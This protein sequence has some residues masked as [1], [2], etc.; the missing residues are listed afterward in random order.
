MIIP[1]IAPVIDR[2][3]R[4]MHPWMLLLLVIIPLVFW[5]YYKIKSG[6]SLK[7]SSL[8]NLRGIKRSRKAI[9][10]SRVPALFFLSLALFIFALARPQSGTTKEKMHTDG[11][12][13]AIS[14][15]I[16]SSMK[17]VD[18]KPENRLGAAKKVAKDF[19]GERENDRIS[20]VI[21]AAH[22]FTQC[23]LTMDYGMI[24]NFLDKVEIGQ[25]EDGTAIGLGLA[26]AANRLANSKSKSKVIVLLTDGVNNRG[27]ID[28]ITAS[29][30]AQALDIRVYTI[31]M[32]KPGGGM[33]PVDDPIFGRRYQKADFDLD[34]DVLTRIANATGG[35][36]F[37]ATDT[38]KLEAIFKEIDEMEK[39]KIEVTR[40]TRYRELGP[41][42]MG[43]GAILFLLYILLNFTVFRKL[44]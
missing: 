25:I 39:T 7:F 10:A 41:V 16:S 26:M 24:I 43:F 12:D 14:L 37:R 40:F 42:F 1:I 11:V 4:F 2:F 31:G 21:F 34:E 6:A 29:K 44:P 22:A 32:G 36:Y 38:D 5:F 28:P 3:Y 18:F 13:I 30:I 35:R 33:M 9:A 8:K 15:D 27:E 17:S 20:L 19:I 23:P